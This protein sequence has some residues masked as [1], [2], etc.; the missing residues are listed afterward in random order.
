M[1]GSVLGA[2]DIALT[3]LIFREVERARQIRKKN[4]IN[5]VIIDYDKG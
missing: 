1:L 5:T 3:R 2:G 4:Q